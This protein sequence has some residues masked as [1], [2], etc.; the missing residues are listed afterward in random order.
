M[1]DTALLWEVLAV[2]EVPL[3]IHYRINV[4]AEA[5]TVVAVAVTVLQAEPLLQAVAVPTTM[6]PAR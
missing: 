6:A 2:E 3:P 1:E 5:D 4:A